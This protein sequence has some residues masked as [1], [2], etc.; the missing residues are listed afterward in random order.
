MTEKKQNDFDKDIELFD[1]QLD[2][3]IYHDAGQSSELPSHDTKEN[4]ESPLY[5]IPYIKDGIEYSIPFGSD[6]SYTFQTAKLSL[7]GKDFLQTTGEEEICT[8]ACDITSSDVFLLENISS[9]ETNTEDGLI[10]LYL[11]Q[12]GCKEALHEWKETLFDNEVY[13]D[14][15]SDLK[16]LS[17]GEY[18]LLLTNVT[19]PENDTRFEKI[20]NHTLLPFRILPNGSGL[21]HPR[22]QNIRIN[23]PAKNGIHTSGVVNI[24]STFSDAPGKYDQFRFRCFHHSFFLMGESTFTPSAERP[25]GKRV[26]T[27]ISSPFIWMPGKY[28]CIIEHNE[29]PFYKI[30]F[31]ID[32]SKER[33]E[34]GEFITKDS[35]EYLMAK[36]L[37]HDDTY[38]SAWAVLKRTAGNETVKRKALEGYRQTIFNRLRKKANTTEIFRNRNFVC[39]TKQA[40]ECSELLYGFASIASGLPYITFIDAE[41][42]TEQKNTA[43]PYEYTNEVLSETK[44]HIICLKHI[45]ALL[46]GNGS[47]IL[48]RFRKQLQASSNWA[49]LI[50][51]TQSEIHSFFESYPEMSSFFPG[52]NRIKFEPLNLTEAVLCMQQRLKSN[53]LLL[54]KEAETFLVSRLTGQEN[55]ENVYGWNRKRIDTFI[56]DGIVPSFQRRVFQEN[57]STA[58][59]KA[60]DL[61]TIIPE[62]IDC[63]YLQ[64]SES[65]CKESMK[66]VDEMVGLSDI[67]KAINSMVN[68][69]RFNNIRK[70]MGLSHKIMGSHHM[71]FTGNPGTGKTSVAK[72]LGKIFHSLGLLSKGDVIVTE[73]SRMVGRFIGETERNMQDILLQAQGNVL[74]IDEAY[75]LCDSA[76]DRKD[77]GYRVIESLLTVLSQK[78]PDII[79]ILAGYEKEMERMLQSN[80]GLRGRFP[81]TFRFNDYTADELMQIGRTLLCRENY[82]LSGKAEDYLLETIKESIKGKDKNFSNARWMEQ[83]IHNGIIPAMADRIVNTT[84]NTDEN[85]YSRIEQ[86]DIETAYLQFRTGTF[87]ERHGHTSIGFR[88]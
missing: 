39:E 15:P 5:F 48:S 30:D 87:P 19:P 3:F 55:K 23:Y 75:T 49:L 7:F 46:T 47:I 45:G 6:S 67:K 17:P 11:Y 84:Q 64:T 76:G 13:F 14:I 35:P 37:E 20:G 83:Y 85:L 43:D 57:I 28:C 18:F 26:K 38:K 69:I 12:K 80:P 51:G 29:E 71:I 36:F 24:T 33:H 1:E 62:D 74:F 22:I 54:S 61:S 16:E 8:C 78:E 9:P 34:S 65:L 81:Y 27:S 59:V 86:S 68:Q 41:T 60:E 79:I 44:D 50:T 56:K 82:E 25:H 70:Q 52:T 88:R 4:N 32:G 2:A 73:R 31:C 72:M 42:L 53:G 21:Q 66:E 58:E 63:R 77:Y 40:E 10:Y